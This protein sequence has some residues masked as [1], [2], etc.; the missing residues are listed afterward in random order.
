M[1]VAR[2]SAWGSIKYLDGDVKSA[3]EAKGLSTASH[4]SKGCDLMEEEEIQCS[5]FLLEILLLTP[6]SFIQLQM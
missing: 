6:Q 4:A 3:F 5:I 1:K 2:R